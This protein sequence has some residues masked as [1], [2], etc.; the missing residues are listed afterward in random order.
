MKLDLSQR[1]LLMLWL[2][3]ELEAMRHLWE[4]GETDSA[5]AHRALVEADIRNSEGRNPSRAS[6]I[7]FYGRMAREGLVDIE[8][9]TWKNGSPY[10]AETLPIGRSSGGAKRVYRPTS[11]SE[12]AFVCWLVDLLKQ[13]SLELIALPRGS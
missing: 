12:E 6:F 11:E 3:W 1:G 7:H 2:P 9:I 5:T 13:K 4:A 10:V 8:L